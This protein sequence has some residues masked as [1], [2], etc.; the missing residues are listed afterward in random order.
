MIIQFIWN[1]LL[2]IKLLKRYKIIENAVIAYKKDCIKSY[3]KQYILIVFTFIFKLYQTL[4]AA[5]S[6][7]MSKYGDDTHKT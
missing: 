5:F 7:I 3:V 1:Y 6:W 2:E 4:S